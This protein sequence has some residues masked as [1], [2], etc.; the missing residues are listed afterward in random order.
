M[1]ESTSTNFTLKTGSA[2]KPS[3]TIT[4]LTLCFW[5]LEARDEDY[6]GELDEEEW[7]KI[8]KEELVKIPSSTLPESMR[9][10]HLTEITPGFCNKKCYSVL[11]SYPLQFY[12]LWGFHVRE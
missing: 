4:V 11:Q 12:S 3:Y 10:A 5:E 7:E 9:C 2:A 6:D 1:S 8:K